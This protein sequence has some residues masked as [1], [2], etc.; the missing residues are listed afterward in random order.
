MIISNSSS[1]TTGCTTC[2]AFS[3][4]LW[5]VTFHSD[6]A[7]TTTLA[8]SDSDYFSEIVTMAASFTSGAADGPTTSTVFKFRTATRPWGS[9]TVTITGGGASNIVAV[10]RPVTSPDPAWLRSQRARRAALIGVRKR[11][12]RRAEGLLRSW[13]TEKQTADL[14]KN[15]WFDVRVPSSDGSSRTYRIR[16]GVAGNVSL[17]GPDGRAVKSFCA[18]PDGVPSP[19]V[20]LSQKLMLETNEDMFLR[21]ANVRE[22]WTGSRPP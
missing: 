13:L 7:A 8:D 2:G 5:S 4:D 19:D 11:A 9:G 1:T 6:S 22:L 17:L 12:E 10:S 14:E 16:R 3:S 15:G 21:I 20:M 18:H